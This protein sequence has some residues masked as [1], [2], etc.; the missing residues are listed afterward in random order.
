MASPFDYINS[1][2]TNKK[3]M[4]RDSENDTLAEKGYNAWIVAKGLSY[5]PDPIFHANLVNTNYHLE[6]RPQYEFLLNSI[7]PG[8]R[9][10]KWFKN[11][12]DD[13]LDTVC[14]YYVCNKNVG[15]EYLSLL[16]PE[17]I[18]FIKKQQE[19]GGTKK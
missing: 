11:E 2:T 4:M 10:A 1:V 5:F 14:A 9:F 18:M 3:N 7:R 6:N 17:Q 15:R 19:T 8:K 16:S 13:D 12:G